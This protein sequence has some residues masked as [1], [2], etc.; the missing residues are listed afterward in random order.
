[1]YIIS[2]LHSSCVTVTPLSQGGAI[3]EDEFAKKIE[4]VLKSKHQ[5]GLLPFLKAS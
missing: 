5:P 1:M 2:T 4:E 3:S